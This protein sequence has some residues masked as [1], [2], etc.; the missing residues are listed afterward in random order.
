M[1]IR[2]VGEDFEVFLHIWVLWPSWSCDKDHLYKLS[3]HVPKE[4]PHNGNG[5]R[6]FHLHIY[7]VN[8]VLCCKFSQIN[9]FITVSPIQMNGQLN[10]TLL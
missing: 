8:L 10:L 1:S 6:K 2:S 4:A 9:D 3:F 7:S 5:E